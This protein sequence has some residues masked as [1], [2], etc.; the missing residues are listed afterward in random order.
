MDD[1]WEVVHTASGMAQAAIVQG[2][3]EAEGIQVQLKY[4]AA[5]HIYAITIDGLGEVKVLVPEPEAE[6]AREILAVT[7]DDKDIDWER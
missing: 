6:K 1:R 7:Y 3:L 5:G 4:E 2:R